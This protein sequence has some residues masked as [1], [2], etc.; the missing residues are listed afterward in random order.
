MKDLFC[1]DRVLIEGKIITADQG[2]SIVEAVAIKDGKFLAVSSTPEIMELV[3]GRTEVIDL[4]HKT[5]LPGLI[6]SHTH[7]S[8]AASLVTEINCRQPGVQSIRDILQMVR[9]RADELGPGKWV[10]G[11]N[12]NDSKLSEKRHITRRELDEAAPDNPVFVLSD[13]GHQCLVNSTALELAGIS[14]HT[15][16]PPGG[17]IDRGEGNEPTGLLYETATLL[18]ARVIPPYTVE[19]LKE[20]FKAV[21]DQFSEWGIT[22][23]HDASG[24]NLAIRAYQ[25]LLK[26]GVKKVRLNLMVSV[27]PKEPDGI[28]LNEAMANLGIESGFG[29]DWLKVMT[30][31]IMGDGSGAGGTA[32]VY[33]TRSSHRG[34]HV[35]GGF[36]LS[37]V[38]GLLL[39]AWPAW[40][41]GHQSRDR[42]RAGTLAVVFVG[43]WASAPGPWRRL[44]WPAEEPRWWRR[45]SG[46]AFAVFVLVRAGNPAIF[47]GEKPMDFAFL[48]TLTRATSLPPSGALV[49]GLD[50]ALH[51]VRPLPGGRARQAVLPA[52]GRHLQPGRRARRARWR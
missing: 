11:G 30:L 48:N 21:L 32:G 36:A 34:S 31:K 24:Y 45:S 38:L 26:E 28:N 19:E 46:A 5:V 1:A 16:D 15:Q 22:S 49:R 33:G 3:G 44:R 29:N 8:M 41:L 43:S 27:F 23:T 51:L 9:G 40:W 39:L 4:K 20:G 13:T 25:Q 42:S 12:F 18:A 14:R 50:P 7:P 47:W 37:R 17:K 10:R 2:D 6:D 35:W 52:P